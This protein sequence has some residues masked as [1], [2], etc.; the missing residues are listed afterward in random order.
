MLAVSGVDRDQAG[1]RALHFVAQTAQAASTAGACGLGCGCGCGRW[2]EYRKWGALEARGLQARVHD[3]RVDLLE[4]G[5][6]DR[7][8]DR[9]GADL[10]L[11]G[12]DT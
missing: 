1:A 7:L 6:T 12:E 8:A 5:A 10:I 11:Y 9:S 3:R 4:Q 2:A